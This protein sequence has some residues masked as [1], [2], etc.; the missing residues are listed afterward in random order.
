MVYALE[1]I[2]VHLPL[3]WFSIECLPKD[4]Y[5]IYFISKYH[6]ILERKCLRGTQE[7]MVWVLTELGVIFKSY[8]LI[9]S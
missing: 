6:V 3:F 2:S 5:L 7:A 9:Y 8:L 1:I 4:W